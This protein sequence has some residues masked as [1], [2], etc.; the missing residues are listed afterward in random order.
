MSADP[1]HMELPHDPAPPEPRRLLPEPAM[2]FR[3]LGLGV[4]TAILGA[5]TVVGF[6][7]GW[8][9]APAWLAT[10]AGS[11]LSL[12]GAVIHLTGGEKFDDHPWV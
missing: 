3:G 11:L 12:W 2:L 10:G 7:A 4:L 5:V 1:H 8:W 9:F 6:K